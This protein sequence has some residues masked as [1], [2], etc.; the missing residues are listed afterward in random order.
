[1]VGAYSLTRCGF[2]GRTL[3]ARVT[4]LAYG[5]GDDSP[6]SLF[7]GHPALPSRGLAGGGHEG[8]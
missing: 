8:L 6:A 1:L 5:D 3:V 7:R 4:A 2:R